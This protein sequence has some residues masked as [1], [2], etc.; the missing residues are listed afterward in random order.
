MLLLLHGNHLKNKSSKYC[1]LIERP[2]KLSPPVYFMS[3]F[4]SPPRLHTL[5][6][7]QVAAQSPAR[8]RGTKTGALREAHRAGICVAFSAATESLRSLVP[9]RHLFNVPLPI[10]SLCAHLGRLK[11]CLKFDRSTQQANNT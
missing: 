7:A 4:L 5:T 3:L 2:R 6:S 9:V 10:T 1:C 8:R 11:T